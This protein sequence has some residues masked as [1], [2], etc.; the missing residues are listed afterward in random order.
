MKKQLQAEGP[1][2]R[3]VTG[4]LNRES[5]PPKAARG[6]GR[7]VTRAALDSEVIRAAHDLNNHLSIIL[8]NLDPLIE[9]LAVAQSSFD[10]LA[11]IRRASMRSR[12]SVNRLVGMV[13]GSSVPP[14]LDLAVCLENIT[15]MLRHLVPPSTVLEVSPGNEKLPVSIGFAELDAIILSAVDQAGRGLSAGGRL[16][17]AAGMAEPSPHP[18]AVLTLE[19]SGDARPEVGRAA[20]SPR[21]G[22]VDIGP[23]VTAAGGKLSAGVSPSGDRML[24]MFLPLALSA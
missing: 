7:P 6:G 15:P 11:A 9:N 14:P 3:E 4:S 13:R 12:D 23:L 1:P 5:P 24:R 8:G 19:T 21:R 22:M 18:G 20:R 16:R 10:D 17:V 2:T